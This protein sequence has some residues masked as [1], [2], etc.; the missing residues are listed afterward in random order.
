LYRLE[1]AFAAAADAVAPEH[2]SGVVEITQDASVSF[3]II[4]QPFIA[5]P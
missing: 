2:R 4:Q 3:E 5:R 1:A